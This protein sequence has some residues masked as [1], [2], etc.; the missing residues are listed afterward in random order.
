M[1]PRTTRGAAWAAAALTGSLTLAAC[2]SGG[3]GGTDDRLRVSVLLPGSISDTGFMQSGHAG[4]ERIRAERSDEVDITFVEEVAAADFEQVLGRMAGE[5]DLVVSVGGQ[6]D[7]D[8][9]AVAAAAPDV[10]FVEIGGPADAEPLENLAYYD[11]RQPEGAYLA[12]VVAA[13][14]SRSGKIGFIGGAELPEIVNSS[15]AFENGARSADP[16]IEVVEPQFLGDFN[17]PARALQAASADHGVGVDVIGQI[18]NLGKSGL[19]QA[20]LEA[21]AHVVGG[22]IAGDCADGSP[23][24]GYVVTD[25]GVQIE[26]AVDAVLDGTWEA[27]QVP[28]GLAG[29]R[30]GTDF[31]LCADDPEVEQ[32]L[33]EA[34]EAIASGAVEPY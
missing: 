5:S 17:D 20:A 21:G 24:V 31:V 32:A 4:V 34:A 14:T 16:G 13:L 12:G 19:E 6:T 25:T 10:T 28:F 7:A 11:P 22:P 26:Y 9:R 33:D 3:G 8:V 2:G 30:V 27:A 1:S 29:D 23:Y 15:H 18:L